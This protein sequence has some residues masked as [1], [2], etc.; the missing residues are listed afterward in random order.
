MLVKFGGVAGCMVAPVR[1]VSLNERLVV[2]SEKVFTA[3]PQGTRMTSVSPSTF[4]VQRHSG[5]RAALSVGSLH[6]HG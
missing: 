6:R 5:H 2:R 4:L 1:N 3:N